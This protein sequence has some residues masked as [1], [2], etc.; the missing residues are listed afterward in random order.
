MNAMAEPRWLSDTE[1]RAWRSFQLMQAT[2]VR[3]L[4]RDLLE[5]SG[6]S[7]A[8][9]AVLVPLSE[10]PDRLLRA[11]DLGRHL[12]WERSRLSHQIRR[13][14]QRGLVERRDC[15]TDARGTFIVL[16]D[17]GWAAIEQAAPPHVAAVRTHLFD[18]LTDDDVR[19]LERIA[20]RVTAGMA[21]MDLPP[22]CATEDV[23]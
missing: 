7:M 12:G 18:A 5:K 10:A 8:D 14:E 17:A 6:L 9:F 23:V 2:L 11:R 4:E 20:G 13:M 15:P 16:T 19:D 21:A 1:Q 22:R 3:A